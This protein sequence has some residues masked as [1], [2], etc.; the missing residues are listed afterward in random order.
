MSG[1]PSHKGGTG[2]KKFGGGAKKAGAKKAGAKKAGAK[3][4]TKKR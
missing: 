1:Q 2:S 3:K 4:G